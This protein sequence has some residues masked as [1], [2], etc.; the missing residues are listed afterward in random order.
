MKKGI[1]AIGLAVLLPSVTMADQLVSFS[2]IPGRCA[3][4]FRVYRSTSA[5]WIEV[6]EV[7]EP[8]VELYVPDRDVR[9]RISGICTSGPLK[10][11]WWM[12]QGV[13]TGKRFWKDTKR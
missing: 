12:R 2:W 5:G 4:Y 7:Y 3:D 9:W 6:A 13:W 8:I 11:E 1:L 10:G